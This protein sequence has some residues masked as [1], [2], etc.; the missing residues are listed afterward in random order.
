MKQLMDYHQAQLAGAAQQFGLKNYF[1]LPYKTGGV[2]GDATLR[3][4]REQLTTLGSQLRE[5][6]NSDGT[7]GQFAKAWREAQ[8]ECRAAGGSGS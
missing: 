3:L 7:S 5:H 1:T 8:P 2:N 4:A 6:P